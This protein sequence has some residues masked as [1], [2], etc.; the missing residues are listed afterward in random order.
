MNMKRKTVLILLLI[1]G[2]IICTGAICRAARLQTSSASS[3]TVNSPVD[4]VDASP[5]DGTCETA[6]G[7]QV[8]TLRAAIQETNALT[9]TDTIILPTG[10]YTLT[11]PGSG[12]DAAATGDLDI[13]GDLTIMGAGATTTIITGNGIDRALHVFGSVEISGVTIAGGATD[14]HPGGGGI[15]N[16]G[17]LVLIDSSITGSQVSSINL[18]GGGVYNQGTLVMTNTVV[19]SNT[20]VSTG[21]NSGGG[22][23]NAGELILAGGAVSNNVSV[24]MGA[25]ILNIGSASLTD[26]T[27]DN[28]QVSA[29]TFGGGIANSSGG[30]TLSIANSAVI[31]NTG[32][33]WGGGIY[34]DGSMVTITNTL[35]GGNDNYCAG[36]S[37]GGG[38][39]ILGFG[40][41]VTV[42]SSTIAY[43]SSDDGGGIYNWGGDLTVSNTTVSHNA[44]TGDGD[45]GGI[46]N[47]YG[48]V[49]LVN[50][51]ISH[52]QYISDSLQ[53]DGG[54]IYNVNGTLAMTNTTIVQNV[55]SGAGGGIYR[56]SGTVTSKNS[57]VADNVPQNCSGDVT[58]MDNN[59]DSGTTC[60]FSLPGD[61]ADTDPTLGPL[62]DNGG[63]TFTHALLVDS[64]A[65]DAGSDTGSPAADQRGVMRPLDGDCDGTATYD[66]GAYEYQPATCDRFVYLPAVLKN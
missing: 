41:V 24:A 35:I 1:L 6:P 59:I 65:I 53:H 22:I 14:S 10:T 49:D 52:N 33:I 46:Y 2:A 36:S 44:L 13:T 23:Y 5:G 56:E 61:L 57:I 48:T 40:N 18:G 21:G 7:N 47:D 20:A 17:S 32:G 60:G 28:N 15:L 25:G 51:T 29:C 26:V 37:A 64:P 19:I 39:L 30:G 11:I 42:V 66:I 38:I 63:P 4:A 16:E 45:G 58:S 54:G 43:N 8:C 9:G 27:V 50:V 34:S 12:E 62:Q 31:S 3:F 55:S